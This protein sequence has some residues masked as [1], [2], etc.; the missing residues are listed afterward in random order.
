[1]LIQSAHQFDIYYPVGCVECEMA[2]T[3][4]FTSYVFPKVLA[5]VIVLNFHRQVSFVESS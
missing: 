1:M 4:R 3:W 2:A 5:A